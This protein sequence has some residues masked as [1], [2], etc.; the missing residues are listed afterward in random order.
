M[1]PVC[2]H[3]AK[4]VT[5]AMDLAMVVVGRGVFDGLWCSLSS[6]LPRTRGR[7]FLYMRVLRRH[8]AFRGRKV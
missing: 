2:V 3:M 6:F 7:A 5:L 4:V 8:S 1:M